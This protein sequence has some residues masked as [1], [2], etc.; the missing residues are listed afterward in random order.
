[1]MD[2]V[3]LM[4]DLD[5]RS[6]EE[7]FKLSQQKSGLG[8]RGGGGVNGGGD[9]N[10]QSELDSPP[11]KVATKQLDSL[12]EHTRLKNM[13]ICRRKL[14]TIP[15]PDL[16][17]AINA[18]DIQMLGMDTVELLQRMVPQVV[19][20]IVNF[21]LHTSELRFILI[22]SSMNSSKRNTTHNDMFVCRRCV[23]RIIFE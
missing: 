23:F 4:K 20:F 2:D 11:K 18:L 13:A 17:R 3:K 14:P 21:P 19:S 10:N 6:F 22:R 12:M 9:N 15:I 7:E 1:M 16:V 8:G 5:F